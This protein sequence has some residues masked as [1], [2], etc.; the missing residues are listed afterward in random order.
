MMRLK[1]DGMSCDHCVHAVPQALTAVD[2]VDA[3]VEVSLERG[4]VV[5]E[6]EPEIASLIAAIEEEGYSAEPSP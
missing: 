6:G 3:V 4:E 2:G 5:I 1:V